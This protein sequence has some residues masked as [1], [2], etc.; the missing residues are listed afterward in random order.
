[1]IL[2]LVLFCAYFQREIT[3]YP[4]EGWDQMGY[5]L[6]SFGQFDVLLKRD[7]PQLD[8]KIWAQGILVQSITAVSY[9]IFGV[10][11]LNGPLFIALIWLLLQFVIFTHFQKRAGPWAGWLALGLTLSVG[12]YFRVI[13]GIVDFR[14]DA[15]GGMLYGMSLIY[16]IES[17]R[18]KQ[19]TPTNLFIFSTLA[20]ILTRSNTI[21]LLGPA[22]LLYAM[23]LILKREFVLGRIW[24]NLWPSTRFVAAG[25]LVGAIAMASRFYRYYLAYYFTGDPNSPAIIAS[26][27]Q[28][29]QVSPEQGWNYR[30]Y[31][32]KIFLLNHLGFVFFAACILSFAGLV[33]SW[34]LRHRS[35]SSA[36]QSI[37]ASGN[38]QCDDLLLGFLYFAIPI[39]LYTLSVSRNPVVATTLVVPA[40]VL[41]G[42]CLVRLNGLMTRRSS[43]PSLGLLAATG[44]L[45]LSIAIVHVFVH[46]T[47]T[48]GLDPIY[49]T[50]EGMARDI[51]A[52]VKEKEIRSY[53]VAWLDFNDMSNTLL[54]FY[55]YLHD[56]RL[57]GYNTTNFYAAPSSSAMAL[58]VAGSELVIVNE[59]PGKAFRPLPFNQKIEE[60]RQAA[61]PALSK[62]FIRLRKE[63]TT[64]WGRYAVYVSKEKQ[65]G[66]VT[67]PAIRLKNAYP[68]WLGKEFSLEIAPE[69]INVL[70]KAI[71]AGESS[72]F[73]N[74]DE[75]TFSVRYISNNP[76]RVAQSV[77]IKPVFEGALY[78][79]SIDI[80]AHLD[81]CGL[82]VTA[83][84]TFVPK[85]IGLNDDTR[86]LVLQ[87][88]RTVEGEEP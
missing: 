57:Y 53:K 58:M 39:S 14:L 4:P 35:Q 55:G 64:I 46:F 49:E 44:V 30:L 2:E 6:N 24:K 76:G 60:Y 42:S 25:V 9:F 87:Y 62:Q 28:V 23:F 11:R 63:Y 69:K 81:I 27:N 88:P 59:A 73:L 51:N 19:K 48:R 66:I 54:E 71:V 36:P 83:S 7:W 38:Q 33:L 43:A 41:V 22:L 78:R 61:A 8:H 47:S 74:K 13:G 31:P 16:L 50:P 32:V 77:V 34:A 45:V 5:Y 67:E 85:Q 20:A 21:L 52:L 56:R 80:P 37:S 10:S 17:E 18:L 3:P 29:M 84:R 79:L 40:V 72:Y 26:M 15:P 12:S 68:D 1:M 65:L 86:E 82:T 70:R 75:L